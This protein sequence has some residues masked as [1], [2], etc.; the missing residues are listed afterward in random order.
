MSSYLRAGLVVVATLVCS[1]A[2]RAQA[3]AAARHQHLMVVVS[4]GLPG[5]VLYDADTDQEIC[6]VPM[7]PAP[8]EAAFSRDGRTLYVPVYSPANIG[9]T[10]TSR[11]R[12]TQATT[13]GHISR[14]KARAGRSTS[15]P[16]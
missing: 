12:S 5:I 14:R 2:I 13:S 9:P 7:D 4:K 6:R 3:P 11:P 8:H 15:P 16:N 1:V 10:A